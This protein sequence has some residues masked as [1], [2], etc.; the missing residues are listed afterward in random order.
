MNTYRNTFLFLCFILSLIGCRSSNDNSSTTNLTVDS[1]DLL[2][3]N[4]KDSSYSYAERLEFSRTAYKTALECQVDSLINKSLRN[5]FD[6]SS[7]GNRNQSNQL[8]HRLINRLTQQNNTKDL[9]SFYFDYGNCFYNSNP[10]SS[11]YYYHQSK[12]QYSLLNDSVGIG[13]NFINMAIIQSNDGDYFGSEKSAIDALTYLK[14]K[15]DT[16]YL[17]SSYN[18]LAIS[19]GLLKNYKEEQYWYDKAYQLSNDNQ[20]KIVLLNNKAVSYRDADNYDEAINIF[21]DLQHRPELVKDPLLKARV[22]DNLAYTRWMQDDNAPV[23][24][25]YLTA[26][27]IRKDEQSKRGT[28]SSYFHLAKYYAKI[29]PKK[30]SEY[31]KKM[32][33]KAKSINSPDDQIDAL[34]LLIQWDQVSSLKQFTNEY[35]ALNDSL[36]NARTMAKHQYAKI[37]FDSDKIRNEIQ[38]LNLMKAEE[39]LEIG[40]KQL[41]TTIALSILGFLLLLSI[42]YHY[43]IRNRRIKEKREIVYQTEVKISRQLHDELA[44]DL[45]STLTLVEASKE[46]IDEKIQQKLIQNLE[47]IYSQTRSI[48]RQN[49]QIDLVRFS[50]DLNLMLASY[51]S[52]DTSIITRGLQQANW[53]LV[54]NENKIILYRVLQEL[55][56]NMRKHSK[57]T[58]VVLNV[59]E[60]AKGI[61]II[62]KDN[63]IGPGDLENKRKNGLKNAENRIHSIAGKL[64]FEDEKG[65]KITLFIPF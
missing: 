4:T 44:N 18:S 16:S 59:S 5:Y 39:E 19:S 8:A 60:K 35:I 58:L 55:M 36:Q 54:R 34:R 3:N 57:S 11:F 40:K 48:S 10:D 42:A 27:S 62:Y 28:I 47:H 17:I 41:K 15:K 52:S 32:L 2:L 46:D 20:E 14:N 24:E 26:L 30:A 7:E 6:I 12:N 64:I 1:V 33:E 61:Q 37:R 22:I 53:D 21:T 56:I 25:D 13:K 45:F 23:L 49:N 65:M 51:Q 50:T 9:A 29:N 38:E 31:A 43:Y 63:G